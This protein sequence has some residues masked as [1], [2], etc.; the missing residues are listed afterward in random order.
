MSSE[1]SYLDHAE[2]R[3]PA[4]LGR[5]KHGDVVLRARKYNVNILGHVLLSLCLFILNSVENATHLRVVKRLDQDACEVMKAI[6]HNRLAYKL[7]ELCKRVLG[8]SLKINED[9]PG[10]GL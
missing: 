5:L 8:R 1:G 6:L 4:L 9:I 7:H 10:L 3:E 2:V